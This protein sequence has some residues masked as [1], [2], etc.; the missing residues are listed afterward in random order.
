MGFSPTYGQDLA[1]AEASATVIPVVVLEL[2]D[3]DALAIAERRSGERHHQFDAA[4]CLAPLPGEGPRQV[5]GVVV[6]Q[7]RLVPVACRAGKTRRVLCCIP[8]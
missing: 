3:L 1:G 6:I 4:H 2:V 8:R 7:G 5:R